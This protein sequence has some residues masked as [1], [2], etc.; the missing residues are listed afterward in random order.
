M[1]SA[2]S[3]VVLHRLAAAEWPSVEDDLLVQA[4]EST[5]LCRI[6]G[7]QQP[8]SL[9]TAVACVSHMV[10]QSLRTDFVQWKANSVTVLNKLESLCSSMEM[11][12]SAVSL[13][14]IRFTRAW[15]EEQIPR[16]EVSA[17]GEVG[18]AFQ[19]WR[20]DLAFAV[21]GQHQ[22]GARPHAL[23]GAIGWDRQRLRAAGPAA[24]P[25]EDAGTCQASES[26][27]K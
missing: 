19:C 7:E 6:L 14:C 26:R 9:S 8:C 27:D 10:F 1:A 13:S 3:D 4:K 2:N 21:S 20:Q 5:W 25:Q 24:L 16:P 18:F 23:G 11:K 12:Q 15:V 17:G 22:S